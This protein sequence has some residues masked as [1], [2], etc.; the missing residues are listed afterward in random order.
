M[1]GGTCINIGCIPTKTLIVS[2]EKGD[3]YEV[4]KQNRDNVVEKLRA[5]NFAGL[6]NNP[7]VDVYTAKAKFIEDKSGRNIC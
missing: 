1:Y 7:Q 2:S 6:N 3:K 5:K 4:A